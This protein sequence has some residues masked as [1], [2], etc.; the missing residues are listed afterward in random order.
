MAENQIGDLHVQKLVTRRPSLSLDAEFFP[1]MAKK[2]G[3]SWLIDTEDV[4]GRRSGGSLAWAGL[5]DSYFWLDP[6]RQ[7]TA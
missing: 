2:W 5:Y 6:K 1:G 4:S 3:L 7:V